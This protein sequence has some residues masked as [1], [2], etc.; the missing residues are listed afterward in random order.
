MVPWLDF[1]RD[2]W[3]S[4]RKPCPKPPC[5]L[6]ELSIA[7]SEHLESAR[8]VAEGAAKNAEDARRLNEALEVIKERKRRAAG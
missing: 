6:E 4:P 8:V 1:W 2:F 3:S 5:S 7:L